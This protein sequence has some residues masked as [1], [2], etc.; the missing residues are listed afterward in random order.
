MN[1]REI[2]NNTTRKRKY[3]DLQNPEQEEPTKIINSDGQPTNCM[4]ILMAKLLISK[5]KFEDA[6]ILLNEHND[7]KDIAIK[8]FC[9]YLIALSNMKQKKYDVAISHFEQVLDAVHLDIDFKNNSPISLFD[10]MLGENS[11]LNVK[12]K[13]DILINTF[14]NVLY[15]YNFSEG[16]T[17]DGKVIAHSFKY[18]DFIA[19]CGLD[20]DELCNALR[21][22]F[23]YVY[24]ILFPKMKYDE[25]RRMMEQ[26]NI[27]L[28]CLEIANAYRDTDVSAANKFYKLYVEHEANSV[29]LIADVLR[30]RI[31]I[32]TDDDYLFCIKNYKRIRYSTDIVNL[33]NKNFNNLVKNIQL[34]IIRFV[35]FLDHVAFSVGGK[36]GLRTAINIYESM[37]A[38]EKDNPIN[39]KNFSLIMNKFDRF[40]NTIT[41]LNRRKNIVLS[42]IKYEKYFSKQTRDLIN[43]VYV[44][45]VKHTTIFKEHIQSQTDLCC[46]CLE[47]ENVIVELKC[48]SVH[49]VCYKCYDLLETC[50]M[51]REKIHKFNL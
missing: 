31:S 27:N 21:N 15:C 40:I 16:E 47:E 17:N 8:V 14:K 28:H 44:E 7:E 1:S 37:T 35:M 6:I 39:L 49:K 9:L 42:Y 43:Q 13:K 41:N 26:Y 20:D 10:N 2:N 51:C 19:N 4:K 29:Y 32:E 34:D 24:C 5:D 18:L 36:Y 45:S 3:G 12:S 48:H 50:P 11:E 30:N 25:L 23:D 46:V 22:T 33:L 38:E